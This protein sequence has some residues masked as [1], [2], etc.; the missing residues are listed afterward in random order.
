MGHAVLA[1]AVPMAVGLAAGHLIPGVVAGL[2]L[3]KGGQLRHFIGGTALAVSP[4]GSQV[5]TVVYHT[6]GMHSPRPVPQI[7]VI[8]LW[9]GTHSLWV[10]GLQRG[11]RDRQRKKR[12][13]E[14]IVCGLQ[15]RA[16]HCSQ[17]SR[18]LRI[19]ISTRR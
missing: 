1:I 4:D 9:T 10:G 14:S 5:A 17:L 18:P 13:G 3:V 19:S 16:T 2:A 8:N 7:M 11:G 15:I 12:S 6:V